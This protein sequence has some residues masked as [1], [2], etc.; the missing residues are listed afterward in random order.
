MQ[1]GQGDVGVR[2]GRLVAH[3]V[4][5]GGVEA[6]RD[7]ENTKPRGNEPSV[8]QALVMGDLPQGQAGPRFARSLGGFLCFITYF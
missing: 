8:A 7:H 3:G 6:V 4:S 2:F 1:L 5:A